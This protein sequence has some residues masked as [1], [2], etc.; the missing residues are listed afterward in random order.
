MIAL[1]TS[2]TWTLLAFLAIAVFGVLA[3]KNMK[4]NIAKIDYPEPGE[5]DYPEPGEASEEDTTK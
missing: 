2:G 4:S 3:W 1:L 5:A